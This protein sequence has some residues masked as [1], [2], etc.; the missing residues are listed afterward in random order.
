MGPSAS[1]WLVEWWSFEGL[2]LMVGRSRLDPELA[3]AAFNAQFS[4]TVVVYQL[5]QG[6][7]GMASCVLV[8]KHMGAGRGG[9][10]ARIAAVAAGGGIL[11]VAVVC[12]A[13]Y[14]L[15]RPISQ[16]FTPHLDVQ[17]QIQETMLGPCVSIPGYALFTTLAGVCRGAGRQWMATAGTVIGF[18]A[19][20]GLSWYLGHVLEWPKPLTG[21]WLGNATAL[22]F[23]AIVTVAAVCTMRLSDEGAGG[24]LQHPDDEGPEPPPD[25]NVDLN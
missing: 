13:M 18:S 9:R 21:I 17:A 7:L 15:R 11:L 12:G 14:M 22:W 10:V 19:G 2:S 5:F 1:I 4:V 8:G 25:L 6:G 3:L 23:A 24:E 16:A 20:L